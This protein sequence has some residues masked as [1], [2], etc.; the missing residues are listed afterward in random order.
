MNC[1]TIHNKLIFY[2]DNELDQDE[3]QELEK[4]LETCSSCN[5]LYKKL[6]G[7]YN[8]NNIPGMSAD[9]TDQVMQKIVPSQKIDSKKQQ[10][11]KFSR[12]IA[13]AV[14]FMLISISAV[15]VYTKQQ[16]KKY[17]QQQNTQE[18]VKTYYFADLDSYDLNTYYTSKTEEKE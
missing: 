11:I 7:T 8:F 5:E 17:T 14:L 12:R 15:F 6:A 13:A 3:K 9:F 18:E 4:H 1:N 2:L 16:Q 10:F